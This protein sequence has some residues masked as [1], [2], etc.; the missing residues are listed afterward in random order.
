MSDFEL[1]LKRAKPSAVWRGAAVL[2]LGICGVGTAVHFFSLDPRY[3]A[4][5][6]H[7]IIT[8]PVFMVF[9][10]VT[11]LALL[12]LVMYPL[13]FYIYAGICAFWGLGYLIDG[14]GVYGF[15]IDLF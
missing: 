9:S 11:M 7:A 8:L 14:G 13:R 10:G 5:G 12:V 3:G 1:M 2:M 4:Q 15:I 6:D